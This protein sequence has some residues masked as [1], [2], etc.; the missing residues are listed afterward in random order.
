MSM[1]ICTRI[2][3]HTNL[4]RAYLKY[5]DDIY[6]VITFTV[7][8]RFDFRQGKNWNVKASIKNVNFKLTF[9]IRSW[10]LW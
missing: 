10:K 8:H 1:W 9:T 2:C 4:L 3:I 5:P 7:P 6:P